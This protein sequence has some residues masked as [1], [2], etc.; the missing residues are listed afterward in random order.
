MNS[1]DKI[2]VR[3]HNVA[4]WLNAA[5]ENENI[6]SEMLGAADKTCAELSDAIHDA[7]VACTEEAE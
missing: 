5:K 7:F 6:R 2:V 4:S 3:L 1:I